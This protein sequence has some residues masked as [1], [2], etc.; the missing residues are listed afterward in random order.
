MGGFGQA[1]HPLPVRRLRS[2]LA[3]GRWFLT[4]AEPQNDLRSLLKNKA[5]RPAAVSQL[6]EWAQARDRVGSAPRSGETR[7]RVA[8]GQGGR[9]PGC[10]APRAGPRAQPG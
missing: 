1:P 10:G 3:Q 6:E 5:I 4:H 9:L 7:L 8:F 2:S